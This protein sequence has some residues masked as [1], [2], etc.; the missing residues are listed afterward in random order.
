MSETRTE[1]ER[2]ARVL[3]FLAYSLQQTPLKGV[4]EAQL[5][6]EAFKWVADFGL[7]VE[8]QLQA[9]AAAAAHAETAKERALDDVPVDDIELAIKTV[10]TVSRNVDQ[11]IPD[12]APV[13][14][15]VASA[16]R[17]ARK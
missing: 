7:S 17:K 8:K 10:A 5:A 1:L 14:R 4:G 6:T 2:T 11:L 15:P 12:S 16:K 13:L 9:V 3:N